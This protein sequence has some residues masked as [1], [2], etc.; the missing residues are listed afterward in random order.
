MSGKFVCIDPDGI[1]LTAPSGE[2]IEHI[3]PGPR[4]D[5]W[6]YSDEQIERWLVQK[7]IKMVG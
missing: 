1:D 5:A 3:E 4:Y 2:V 7:R 6:A